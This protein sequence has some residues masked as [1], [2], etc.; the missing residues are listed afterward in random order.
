MCTH[1]HIYIYTYIYIQMY[2]QYRYMQNCIMMKATIDNNHNHNNHLDINGVIGQILCSLTCFYTNTL[3]FAIHVN[4]YTS[5]YLYIYIHIYIY[6]HTITYIMIPPGWCS[7]A[8]NSSHG[9]GGK[10]WQPFGPAAPRSGCRLHFY[11]FLHHGTAI[12]TDIAYHKIPS[13]NLT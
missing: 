1:T 13:G 12:L 2:V 8:I 10:S 11:I 9:F 7:Q 5:I 3:R 6:T 4:M